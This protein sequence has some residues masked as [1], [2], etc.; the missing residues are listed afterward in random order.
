MCDLTN[1]I[2]RNENAARKHLESIRWPDGPYCPY[3]GSVDK[4]QPLKGKSMGPGWYTCNACRKK[5]TV[6]V[7]TVYER[8]HI[9]LHKWVLATHLMA[10]SKKGIS[11]HQLHRMLGITYKS[12]W[13]MAHRIREAMKDG[14]PGPLGGAG[15]SV[16]ADETYFG[17]DDKGR[18]YRKRYPHLHDKRR[19]HM[20]V[21]SLVEHGGLVR[22]FKVDKVNS[23]TVQDIL[24]RNVSRKSDLLTDEAGYYR[25]LGAEFASH[26]TVNHSREEY[27]RGFG[28]HVNTLEGYFS[29]FKRGMK[30]IYQHCSEKHL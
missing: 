7:G 25:M 22:S 5:F 6:R 15:K 29:L 8:S 27:A 24:F 14:N 20:K 19:R 10:A 28:I 13:F 18:K 26:Q 12:A 23:D 1:P 11:A 30:G 17:T 9:P 16:E 2:Y 3:C 21:V 4:I